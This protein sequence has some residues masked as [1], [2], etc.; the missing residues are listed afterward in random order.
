MAFQLTNVAQNPMPVG[1][2]GP[3]PVQLADQ[4]FTT[5]KTT[6]A[7][8]TL[9]QPATRIRAVVYIKTQVLGATTTAGSGPIFYLEAADVSAMT[10]GLTAGAIQQAANVA[11]ATEVQCLT[12]DLVV[13]TTTSKGFARVVVDP[14]LMGAGSSGT[15]DVVIQSV[16]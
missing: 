14:T 5:T 1:V 11:S 9:P 8:Q 15:Y 6:T 3:S 13:P 2:V 10:T 7:V 12:L 4:T 16:V